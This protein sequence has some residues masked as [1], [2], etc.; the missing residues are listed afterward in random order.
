[1]HSIPAFHIALTL[2]GLTEGLIQFRDE[3]DRVKLKNFIKKW[4]EADQF[5]ETNP[6]Q[7]LQLFGEG[8]ALFCSLP[9]YIQNAT[10][11]KKLLFT[12]P[13]MQ[14][15]NV[16]GGVANTSKIRVDFTED[17]PVFT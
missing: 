12:A 10:D 4:A 14:A 16:A 6:R 11:R 2:L 3:D 15:L 13:I 17:G 8:F 1:M 5:R 9:D 7:F